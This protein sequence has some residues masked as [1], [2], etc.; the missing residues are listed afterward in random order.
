MDI[1]TLSAQ[2][3]LAKSLKFN[4]IKLFS[5]SFIP[6]NTLCMNGETIDIS[7]I[8]T[9][10]KIPLHNLVQP[11]FTNMTTAHNETVQYVGSC[12]QFVEQISDNWFIIGMDMGYV[13]FLSKNIFPHH[14]V[15]RDTGF[16]ITPIAQGA[17]VTCSSLA[18]TRSHIVS[19]NRMYVGADLRCNIC[20]TAFVTDHVNNPGQ[21]S[22]ITSWSNIGTQL[23]ALVNKHIPFSHFTNG[24]RIA[25]IAHSN[26]D[27]STAYIA[28]R[29]A[30]N[31]TRL[32]FRIN[33]NTTTI[34]EFT[35]ESPTTNNASAIYPC[36]T[37]ELFTKIN[38]IDLETG[39][40]R[41]PPNKEPIL[42]AGVE[43][44]TTF[45]GKTYK[46]NLIL[47]QSKNNTTLYELVDVVENMEI[48]NP[49]KYVNPKLKVLKEF[50]N[51]SM[52]CIFIDDDTDTMYCNVDGTSVRGK[53]QTSSSLVA[54][55]LNTYNVEHIMTGPTIFRSAYKSR[56][57]NTLLFGT[58]KGY[59][60]YSINR[61]SFKL[62]KLAAP[63]GMVYGL[64]LENS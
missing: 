40:C 46:R 20:V 57:K 13:S 9:F 51:I 26:P 53:Y 48:S 47:T 29:Y 37:K 18:A 17:D 8:S 58:Q 32:V 61:K 15:N 31:N 33:A 6:A 21:V 3:K 24:T 60:M 42:G 16:N 62:P 43:V 35:P 52:M 55:D 27:L 34:E 10:D 28:V 23:I 64:T 19:T 36:T 25:V 44:M 50:K 22:N 2:N 49:I 39:A 4:N 59:Y 63:Q 38:V 5:D 14:S 1:I 54:I 7:N 45:F 41:I 11:T 30:Y 56:D 12:N